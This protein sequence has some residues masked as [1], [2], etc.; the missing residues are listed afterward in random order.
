MCGIFGVISD[1]HFTLKDKKIKLLAKLSE[2]RGKDSSG[3]LVGSEDF[4]DIQ[5]ADYS[6]TSLYGQASTKKIK[7]ALGHSRLITNGNSDNQPIYK[8][9]IIVFHNGIIIN[10]EELWKSSGNQRS[11]QIDTEIIAEITRS[12]LIGN[13]D[14]KSLCREIVHK[15]SGTIA[16]AIL[17]P[18]EGK[19]ILFSNNGS[20]FLGVLGDYFVFA[21][22]KSF[23]K[24]I[25]CINI[26]QIYEP[27]I[28]DC[29]I[30]NSVPTISSLKKPRLKLLPAL[31]FS[32]SERKILIHRE[33]D[34]KRCSK[35]ILPET[36]PFIRFDSEG[37]CNYCHNYTP[38]NIPRPRE[39][40]FEL[41]ERY[42][43][44]IGSDCIIPLSGGRD[45]FF[46][47]DMAVSEL[48]LKPITYTYDWG[49]VTDLARRN[50]SRIC[51]DLGVENII[52]AA[53]ITRKRLNIQKNLLAWLKSPHLG[54]IS[55]LTA[56]DKHFFKYINDVKKSTGI[57]LNL[58][59]INPLE[60]THFKAGFLGVPPNFEEKL[61]Y[62]SGILN[63][64]NYQRLRLGRMFENLDYF[65]SS[66]YDTLSGEFYR[67]FSKK[68]DY[69]HIF[70]YWK[71]DESLVGQI[72]KKYSF[73]LS[74]DT[75]SSWRIGDGTAG[76]YNYIYYNVAGFT[77]NDTFRSNQIREGDLNREEALILVKDENQPRYESIKWYLNAVDIDFCY[78]MRIVNNIKPLFNPL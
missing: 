4:F 62:S 20:L 56:G 27:E 74:P 30:L 44:E 29:C 71:W 9:D 52:F 10:H 6:I 64:L 37:V 34:L 58:W 33:H 13:S 2:S 43:R 1:N 25:K 12:F 15:C 42:R 53:D 23:L 21:S 35:C 59:G 14:Y 8:D 75:S 7:I 73:E 67:T 72:L 78:A 48:G 49:M 38:R 60:V 50:I 39:E 68:R 31:T 26:K 16:C 57:N 24:K 47:L 46:C 63:Q 5:K 41:V 28:L 3:I 32:N 66:I 17:L 11:L 36:M 54:M 22:E 45:S 18:K 51:A 19:L 65:N 77:E 40:L 76:F 70:D 61:V 55:L 69:F